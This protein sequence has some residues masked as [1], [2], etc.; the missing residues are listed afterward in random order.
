MPVHKIIRI[1]DEFIR[2]INRKEAL[3]IIFG[4]DVG[5][6]IS[7]KLKRELQAHKNIYKKA[8]SQ[9]LWVDDN[10]LKEAINKFEN[11]LRNEKEYNS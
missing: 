11:Y 3:Y 4:V 10:R 9:G 7:S 8:L 6:S 1:L 5:T 2:E